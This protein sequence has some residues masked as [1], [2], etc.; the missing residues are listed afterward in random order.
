M[1]AVDVI[2]CCSLPFLHNKIGSDQDNIPKI[3]GI[4]LKNN[5]KTQLNSYFCGKNEPFKHIP[6]SLLLNWNGKVQYGT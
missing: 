2:D 6:G 1:F 5:R 4:I 3:K